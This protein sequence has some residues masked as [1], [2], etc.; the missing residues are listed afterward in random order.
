M[1][2]FSNSKITKSSTGKT[3]CYENTSTKEYLDFIESFD[4][5]KYSIINISNGYFGWQV[6]Y[7]LKE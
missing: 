1:G 6:T 7:K 4:H 5:S 3:L 2:L